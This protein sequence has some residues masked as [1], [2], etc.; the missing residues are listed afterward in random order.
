MIAA[1]NPSGERLDVRVQPDRNAPLEHQRPGR[2]VGESSAAGRDHMRRTLQQAGYHQPLAVAEMILAEPFEN[3]SDAETRRFLDLLVRI[4]EGQIEPPGQASP[5]AGLARAHQADEDDRS[6]GSNG[7][8]GH[9]AGAIQSALGWG[10]RRAMRRTS[11]APTRRR[12][13]PV[14][15]ILLTLL[16]LLIGFLIY[17]STVDTEVPIAPIEQDVTNEVLAQ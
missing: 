7:R 6:I 13:S 17:L 2:G 14:P 1:A 11:F 8:R 5:H 3:L 16:A 10:K 15:A 4:G 9:Q 12:R